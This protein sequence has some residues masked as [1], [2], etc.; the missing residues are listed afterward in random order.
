M[1]VCHFTGMLVNASCV[2]RTIHINQGRKMTTQAAEAE[3]S[4]AYLGY[5]ALILNGLT[6]NQNTA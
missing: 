3:T 2:I 5:A 4:E 1:I 6:S